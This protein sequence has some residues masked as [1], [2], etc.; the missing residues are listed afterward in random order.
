MKKFWLIAAVFGVFTA[1]WIPCSLA[2][3]V[4]LTDFNSIAQI[5]VDG[6]SSMWQWKVD[7]TEHLYDQSFWY[8]I[9]DTAEQNIGSLYTSYTL[10]APNIVTVLYDVDPDFSV[11]V[12]YTLYGGT[13][14]SEKSD[15]AESIRIINKD[16]A[17][18]DFHFYQYTDFDLG[19]D[20]ENDSVSLLNPQTFRQVDPLYAFAEVVGTPA[21]NRYEAAVYSYT[22]D[23]LTDGDADDLENLSSAGPEDV[24]FTW[25]WDLN[26]PVGDSEVL[27]KDKNIGPVTE[28]GILLLFGSG[29]IGLVTF[30][31]LKKRKNLT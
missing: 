30:A 11:Q 16:T 5:E 20:A 26:M 31:R 25:Q 6:Y 28:P 4:T 23:K 27:S 12:T 7:D 17:A 18:L 3:T 21:A 10:N 1:L 29:L 8:R 24:T 9:G 22:W 15:I 2:T 14:G 19:G 13:V